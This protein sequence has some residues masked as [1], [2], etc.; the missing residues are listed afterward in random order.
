MYALIITFWTYFILILNLFASNNA[1][2]ALW[3]KYIQK[4][5]PEIACINFERLICDGCK[6]NITK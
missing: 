5:D 2:G 3:K 4:N 6:K 1:F